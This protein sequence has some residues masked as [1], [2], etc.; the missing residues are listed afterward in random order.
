MLNDELLKIFLNHQ[1]Q[2]L[3]GN[4]LA[5]EMNVSRT[6]VW[7][8][9][10]ALK[11]AGY[12]I[13]GK[14]NLGYRY[15]GTEQLSAQTIERLCK[16]PV[17][18][19]TFEEI[20]STNQ[21][22]KNLINQ[23]QITTPIVV[24]ANQ[25]TEGYGRRGRQFYSPANSGLYLTIAVAVDHHTKIDPGLLTTTTAVAVVHALKRSYPAIDFQLK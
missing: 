16:Q 17:E 15:L 20:G 23:H 7:K 18:V 14:S 19:Q 9:I 11:A 21:Y 6:M 1:N 25:Q 13:E 22:V 12:Q 24:I 2:W 10:Q 8:R 4:Q 5:A 3:S